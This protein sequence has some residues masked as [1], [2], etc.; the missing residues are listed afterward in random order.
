MERIDDAV[1][2]L[3]PAVKVAVGRFEGGGEV[4]EDR[5]PDDE[6]MLPRVGDRFG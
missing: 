3:Q 1:E 4:F 5:H 6:P 2:Q